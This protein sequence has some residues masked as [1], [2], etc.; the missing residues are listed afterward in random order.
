MIIVS[1]NAATHLLIDRVGL[2]SV[3]GAAAALGLGQTRLHHKLFRA[4]AGAPANCT[5][6]ADLGRLLWLIACQQVLT[7]RLCRDPG[8]PR[9]PARQGSHHPPPARLG[10]F[11]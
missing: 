4:P 1:D 9:P 10:W 7:R 11:R 3:N 8:H 2:D 5:S 6:P